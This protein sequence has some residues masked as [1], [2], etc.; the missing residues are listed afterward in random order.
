MCNKMTCL[1][2]VFNSQTN[3]WDLYD[4]KKNVPERLCSQSSS[5]SRVWSCVDHQCPK[6]L[7]WSQKTERSLNWTPVERNK[8]KYIKCVIYQP[9]VAPLSGSVLVKHHKLCTSVYTVLGLVWCGE[10]P[11]LPAVLAQWSSQRCPDPTAVGA[12]PVLETALASEGQTTIPKSRD[13]TRSGR[14]DNKVTTNS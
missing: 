1:P 10:Y 4:I 14:G 11:R 6:H 3:T 9:I 5:S 12:L 13:L 2:T 8:N 7:T